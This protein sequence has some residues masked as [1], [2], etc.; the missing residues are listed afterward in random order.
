MHVHRSLRGEYFFLTKV[1]LLIKYILVISGTYQKVERQEMG[2]MVQSAIGVARWHKVLLGAV[3]SRG[4][5]DDTGCSGVLGWHRMFRG[6]WITRGWK[7]GREYRGGS[8]KYCSRKGFTRRAAVC[9]SNAKPL[10][11]LFNLKATAICNLLIGTDQQS[12]LLIGH[13]MGPPGETRE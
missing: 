10:V 8:G 11:L 2:L 4:A 9:C 12:Y 6:L 3:E 13:S 7:A 1:E 5:Q